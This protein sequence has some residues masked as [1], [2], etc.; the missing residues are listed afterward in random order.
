[1][2]SVKLSICVSTLLQLIAWNHVSQM[3]WILYNLQAHCICHCAQSLFWK[4]TNLKRKEYAPLLR[5]WENSLLSKQTSCQKEVIAS[6][7]ELPPWKCIHSPKYVP[8]SGQ[9]QQTT[10][11]W[12]LSFPALPSLWPFMHII[13]NGDNLHEMSKPVSWVK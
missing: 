1:M 3:F 10:N 12:Y 4:R 11:W 5:R 8:L 2:L 9:I 7:T 6:L 13:S